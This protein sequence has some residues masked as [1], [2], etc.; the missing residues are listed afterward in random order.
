MSQQ[1]YEAFVG[2]HITDSMLDK[3]AELFS[4]NYRTWGEH[5]HRLGRDYRFSSSSFFVILGKP[6]NISG[7]LLREKYLSDPSAS[8]HARATFDGNLAGSVFACSWKQDG[9]SV[10]WVTQLVVHRYYRGIGLQSGLLRA[11]R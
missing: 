6:I 7:R 11:L 1:L 3:A 10:C 2:E 8:Y 9:K 4:E 5:S